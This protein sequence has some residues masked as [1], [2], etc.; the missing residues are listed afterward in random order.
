MGWVKAVFVW[1]FV[2][3]GFGLIDFGLV[4]LIHRQTN[5]LNNHLTLIDLICECVCWQ[6]KKTYILVYRVAG[7]LEIPFDLVKVC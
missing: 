6:E 7:Q 5:K 1:L 3:V 2:W 4:W